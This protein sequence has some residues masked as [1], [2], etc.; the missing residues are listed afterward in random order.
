MNNE[1][2]L[3]FFENP[4]RVNFKKILET[5]KQESDEIEFKKEISPKGILKH[6]LAMANSGGGIIIFGVEEN[7]NKTLT[8]S[9][10][11]K[12]EDESNFSYLSEY[13]GKEMWQLLNFDYSGFESS[14]VKDKV[15]QILLIK[16]DKNQVPFICIKDKDGCESGNIFIRRNTSSIKANYKEIQELINKR[17]INIKKEDCLIRNLNELKK[18]MQKEDWLLNLTSSIAR[19]DN[20]EYDLFLKKMIEKKKIKIENMI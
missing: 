12:Y 18:M 15:F 16:S 5:C 6:V 19:L 17:I 11:K 10:L 13:I 9:G 20:S 2:F 1:L 7:S 4:D 14:V 3:P 8:C